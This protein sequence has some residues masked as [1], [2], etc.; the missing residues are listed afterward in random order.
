VEAILGDLARELPGWLEEAFARQDE[1][2][3]RQEAEAAWQRFAR[4][5]P[6][7]RRWLVEGVEAYQTAA[8]C[9]KLCEESVRA[10]AHDP[11][12]ALALARLAE[13][14]AE[15]APEDE[16]F[17]LRLRGWALAFVGNAW[18]VKGTLRESDK[19][20]TRCREL[21]EAG[22]DPTGRLPSSRADDLEASLRIEQD[23]FTEALALLDRELA[24]AKPDSVGALYIKKAN[25]QEEVGDSAGA[26]ATLEEAKVHIDVVHQPRLH[27]ARRFNTAGN[28]ANLGRFAEARALLPRLRELVLDLGVDLDRWRVRW[29]EGR[30]AAGLGDRNEAIM[31]FEAVRQEFVARDILYDAGLATLE[32]AALYLA[33]GQ[34]GTVQDLSR[35]IAVDFARDGVVAEARSAMKLFGEAAE[36]ERLTVPLLAEL[37]RTLRKASRRAAG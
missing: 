13:A 25:A 31:A 1:H 29:L 34:W 3:A 33:A 22:A 7:E 9:Q 37:R 6:P 36:R 27:F 28:L 14:A 24:T 26:L 15:R 17:R 18:R 10:A 32:L 21:W 16:A 2:R 30:V 19:A 23:R 12:A 4:C 8:F 11:P 20:F 35:R 5:S